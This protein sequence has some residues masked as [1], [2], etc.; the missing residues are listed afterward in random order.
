MLCI[1]FLLVPGLTPDKQLKCVIVRVNTQYN[2][3]HLSIIKKVF[4][5]SLLLVVLDYDDRNDI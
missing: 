3:M 2:T 5:V 4:V 1:S